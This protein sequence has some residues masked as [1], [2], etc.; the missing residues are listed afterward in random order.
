MLKSKKIALFRS[1]DEAKAAREEAVALAASLKFKQER[2]IK[3]AKATVEE[4]LT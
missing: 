2:L 3:L 4:K 1:L